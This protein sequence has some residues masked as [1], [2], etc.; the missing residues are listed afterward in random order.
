M[1]NAG[2]FFLPREKVNEVAEALLVL[3]MQAKDA[4]GLRVPVQRSDGGHVLPNDAIHAVH[5]ALTAMTGRNYMFDDS[6]LVSLGKGDDVH[7]WPPR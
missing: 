2:L 1:N 6:T 7:F 5:V 3:A 4:K